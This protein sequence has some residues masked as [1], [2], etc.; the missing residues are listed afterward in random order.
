VSL[1]L[2][3]LTM[4]RYFLEYS[5]VSTRGRDDLSPRT[6]TN[7]W[8]MVA[9]GKL[10]KTGSHGLFRSSM[11]DLQH[12]ATPSDAIIV[13]C[14]ITVWRPRPHCVW[15]II[16]GPT[17]LSLFLHLRQLS[18]HPGPLPCFCV[19][20]ACNCPYHHQGVSHL[21]LHI[22]RNRVQFAMFIYGM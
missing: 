22:N 18:D 13:E 4:H 6:P 17:Q 3:N 19:L 9:I 10:H 7:D 8:V 14:A 2:L 11:Q 16:A 5:S 1:S 15:L 20:G 12:L 21:G